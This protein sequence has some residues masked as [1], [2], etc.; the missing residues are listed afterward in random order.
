MKLTQDRKIALTPNDVCALA[1]SL[2]AGDHIVATT[3]DGTEYTETVVD[4]TATT[5]QTGKKVIETEN[6]PLSLYSDPEGGLV[7]T[8]IDG[9]AVTKLSK[10][11]DT[12]N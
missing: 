10:N 5:Q 7:A 6:N 9:E 3:L 4:V 12:D 1:D 11:N 2:T 8:H